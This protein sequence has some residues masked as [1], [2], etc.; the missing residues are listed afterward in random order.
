MDTSRLMPSIWFD[1]PYIRLNFGANGNTW[2]WC[3]SDGE[4]SDKVGHW[5]EPEYLLGEVDR[6]WVSGVLSDEAAIFARS[7]VLQHRQICFDH[8]TKDEPK[9]SLWEKI[10][11]IAMGVKR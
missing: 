5:T 11:M 8:H 10:L 7:A 3:D 4:R 9:P 1:G 2:L 6:L